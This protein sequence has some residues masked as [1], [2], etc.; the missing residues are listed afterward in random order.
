M[1]TD[2]SHFDDGPV[3]LLR[4]ASV[5]A[6]AR[7][8]GEHVD[9]ARFRSNI[10]VATDEAFAE[11]EWIGRH[12]QI[13]TALLAVTMAS[14]RCVMVDVATVDSPAQPGVLSAVGRAR[15]RLGVVARVVREGAVSIGDALIVQIQ[16]A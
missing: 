13:G 4:S 5:V 15:A 10:M 6:V 12:V 2:V 14:P 9:P 16:H 1:E 11:E 3:S 7:E 8:H